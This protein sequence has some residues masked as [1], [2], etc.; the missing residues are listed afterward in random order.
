LLCHTIIHKTAGGY[1]PLAGENSDDRTMVAMVR[2]RFGAKGFRV[3]VP[4]A[5]TA[6][7]AS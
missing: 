5:A 2:I 7:R 3:V 6:S 1:L 4:D